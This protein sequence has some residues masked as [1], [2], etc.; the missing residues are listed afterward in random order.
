MT[1]KK[2]A[3]APEPFVP[4]ETPEGVVPPGYD[5]DAE[6]VASFVCPVCQEKG[7]P[8]AYEAHAASHDVLLVAVGNILDDLFA[9]AGDLGATEDDI[10]RA[11][12][13]SLDPSVSTGIAPVA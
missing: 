2:K 8:A 7:E 3:A 9:Q 4:P 13:L 10:G 6:G 11:L 12:A 1:K 5:I